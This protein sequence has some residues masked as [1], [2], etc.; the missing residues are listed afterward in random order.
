MDTL[1]V[2]FV[3]GDM[4]VMD[5][6]Q[7]A[8]R[9]MDSHRTM[10]FVMNASRALELMTT[11]RFQ[12][13]VS[14]LVLPD[15]DGIR[16]LNAIKAAHPETVRFLLVDHADVDMTLQHDGLVHQFL[17]KESDAAAVRSAVARASVLQG[18]LQNTQL[19]EL[20]SQIDT[21][22]SVPS[23]YLQVLKALQDPNVSLRN[24]AN[25]IAQDMGMTAKVLKVINSAYFG[26][27][28][29]VSNIQQAVVLMGKDSTRSL[30]LAISVFS[31]FQADWVKRLADELYRHSFLVGVY[32]KRIVQ[33]LGGNVASLDNA[34][35]A[36]ILHDVGKLLLATYF[37]K[38]Y[39]RAMQLAL[40]EEMPLHEAE[41][42]ELG[43]THAEVG[44]YLLGIWGL[45]DDIV[46]TVAFHQIPRLCPLGP[47]T[48]LTAVHIANAFEHE[49]A[50]NQPAQP[51][52]GEEESPGQIDL[53]YLEQQ[54]AADRLPYWRALCQVAF[55]ASR[56]MIRQE[57]IA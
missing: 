20:L 54:G 10:Q 47:S 30:V 27:R 51:P 41:T 52:E 13:V 21:L 48:V 42:R 37:P 1:N 19:R 2:L 18:L 28:H 46:Q 26:L 8:L 5:K 25:L 22:P 24:V 4:A 39:A 50:T 35:V 43:V 31:I 44:A 49:D 34:L 57:L 29:P 17:H 11:D 53:A 38:Q 55:G 45:T 7:E 23:V 56:G 3:T 9:D 12:L 14:D 6:L 16:L 15:M 33:D 32:A 36:G 40:Q